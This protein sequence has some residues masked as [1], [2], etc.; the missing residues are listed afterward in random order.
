MRI[1][2]RYVVRQVISHALLG[3]AVFTFVFFVPRLV[4]LMELIVRHGGD[5]RSISLLFLS[6]LPGVFTF[7]VPMAVLVG[8]LI[9]L[10]R[11]SADSE[12][13]AL[14]ASGISLRRILLP[15]G[16]LA[17]GG[18]AITLAMTIWLGPVSVH[19]FRQTQARLLA[20]QASFQIQPRVFEETF[21]KLVLYVHDVEASGTHWHGVFLAESG[22]NADSRLTVADDALVIPG[23][24]PGIL[25]FH[26]RGG[27][28]HE[29]SRREPDRYSVTTFGE[30]DWPIDVSGFNTASARQ[31]TLQ[32]RSLGELWESVG[33]PWR[34]AHV[35]LQRRLAFPAA[36]LVFALIAVPLGARPRRGGRAAGFLIALALIAA[37]YL[38]FIVG[39]G[40]ARQAAVSPALGMWAANFVVGLLGL[41]LLP[42]ME[43]L[44][45]DTWIS[46]AV[47]MFSVWSR[48]RK[49]QPA[50]S[51]AIRSP[52][53]G[54]LNGA[55]DSN[56]PGLANVKS[57]P[58]GFRK[59][60]RFPQLM[61]LYILRNFAYY[62]FVLLVG[63]I[64]LIEA[65]TFFELFDDIARHRTPFL[66]VI[67][68]FRYFTPYL[69][70]QVAPLAA[71]VG[72]LVT[73]G[74]MTKNNEIVAFKASGVSLYRLAVPLLGAGLCLAG[75]MLLLDDT[76][77]PY[78]VQRQDELRNQIKGKPPRTFFQPRRQWIFGENSKMY[79]YDLFDPDR[80][81]FGGLN[82]F[83]L[84]NATFQIKRRVFAARAHWED[85]QNAWI[86]ESGWVRDFDASGVTRYAPFGV[87]TL[88]ELTEPPGY[89][90]RE[91]RQASKM[92][93]QELRSY[94]TDLH[95][96]GFD[97]ATL[98]VQWHKKLA[99][100]F[101][102]PV[103][104]LL[105]FPFALL[106][107][108]RGAVGGVALGVGVAI[109]YWAAATLLEVMGGVGELPPLL[110]GWSP[111]FIFAFLG[112]YFFLK[113]PT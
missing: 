96:A 35:E 37:Y 78:S 110:A 7:T 17:A 1:L 107:G 88:P 28:T 79:N 52:L 22:S 112:V 50:A 87:T 101:M 20:S 38:L 61:D 27:S 10:G 42:G 56:G 69:A 19:F 80:H 109:V 24:D 83:E 90:T 59:S 30:S 3:L 49:T 111:D 13:I 9:G 39:A 47:D 64:F 92:N 33:I 93:W 86:L 63:F 40:M 26:F 53:G 8:I 41:L 71:L 31:P 36:C 74:L 98:T 95:Q 113:M 89:F 46:H 25:Q 45:E 29:Y 23:S 70:Y 72:V 84:D 82:V 102:A 81:L 62:F 67:D 5:S 66:V 6:T 15:V 106:V 34:D 105:A 32:E 75:A 44:H 68:Y 108:T 77:L 43:R 55:K 97:V 21:P 99:F 11:M 51:P 60:A 14:N 16:L 58:S 48:R 12:L 2:D 85:A 103:I 57:S 94:I 18:T 65:F 54:R 73:L 100:P 4:L 76:F 91:V 104:M